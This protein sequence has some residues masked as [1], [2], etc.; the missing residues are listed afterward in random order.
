MAIDWLFAIT[1]WVVW[2]EKQK[3]CHS[4]GKLE[5][6]HNLDSAR[7]FLSA[8]RNVHSAKQPSVDLVKKGS[9]NS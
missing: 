7:D 3:V 6:T 2:S 8:F 4:I 1:A 9:D 5:I